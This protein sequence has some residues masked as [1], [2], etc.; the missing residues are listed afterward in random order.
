M[1][2]A[3]AVGCRTWC[4]VARLLSGK[5]YGRKSDRGKHNES[6]GMTAHGKTLQRNR[7]YGLL[8]RYIDLETFAG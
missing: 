3:F 5:R 7:I 4:V 8:S 2:Q 1:L 6:C